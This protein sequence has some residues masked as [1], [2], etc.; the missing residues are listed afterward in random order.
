MV[1]YEVRFNEESSVLKTQF[2]SLYVAGIP[3]KSAYE[4]A[5]QHGYVGSKEQWL[6]SLKGERGLTGEKGDKGE[7][8]A[9]GEKGDKGERGDTPVKGVDYFSQ[10]DID[11]MVADVLS[12][13][14][15]GDEE[16]Y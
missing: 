12:A 9:Q 13:L 4:I 1:E 10:S 6:T 5:L 14:P 8:G 15:N 3:G 2:E 11:A 16:V 7:Q